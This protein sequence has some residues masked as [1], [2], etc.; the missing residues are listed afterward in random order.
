MDT[1]PN[2]HEEWQRVAAELRAYREHQQQTWGEVDNA[3]LGLYLAGQASPEDQRRVEAAVAEYP[4]LGKLLNLVDE[5]LKEGTAAEVNTEARPEV[6]DQP[7]TLPLS[8]AASRA[9]AMSNRALPINKPFRWAARL[10]RHRAGFAAAACLLLT[11][12]AA[13][14]IWQQGSELA[15]L[16]QQQQDAQ[17]LAQRHQALEVALRADNQAANEALKARS[18]AAN[19]ALRADNQAAIEANTALLK[20]WVQDRIVA[21]SNDGHHVAMRKEH[22]TKVGH[23]S[24]LTEPKSSSPQAREL[25]QLR[26]QQLEMAAALRVA[27]KL[28]KEA[29]AQVAE[30]RQAEAQAQLAQARAQEDLAAVYFTLGNVNKAKALFGQALALVKR[31]RGDDD[32]QVASS[33]NNLGVMLTTAQQ[34]A[35]ARVYLEKAL[36]MRTKNS[37]PEHPDV[38]ATCA[39]LGN[40]FEA[41]GEH[42]RALP[43]F[44]KAIDITKRAGLDKQQIAVAGW[45]NLGRAY[46][47]MQEYDKAETAFRKALAGAGSLPKGKTDRQYGVILQNL[48]QVYAAKGD[49]TRAATMKQQYVELFGD[50]ALFQQFP[51]GVFLYPTVVH[52]LE[53]GTA[54]L[55]A[56]ATPSTSPASNPK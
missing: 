48:S 56:P 45:N 17:L 8:S 28:A 25:A 3:T 34:P 51:A 41:M 11:V 12:G 52:D 22:D 10:W 42:S 46:L 2:P 50:P 13:W 21:L 49:E 54:V 15:Q 43:L 19:A 24:K 35:E 23:A 44:Q 6:I 39:A 16:R 14:L 53:M 55:A 18:H 29:K 7:A 31:V 20:S 33:Y 30:L 37:G 27:T 5:V 38:A 36:D 32:P 40:T 9:P 26:K 4:E 1:N 47:G